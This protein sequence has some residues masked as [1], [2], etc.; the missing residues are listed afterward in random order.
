MG[1]IVV[2]VVPLL[3]PPAIVTIVRMRW[4]LEDVLDGVSI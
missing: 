3:C 4:K 1:E 2:V